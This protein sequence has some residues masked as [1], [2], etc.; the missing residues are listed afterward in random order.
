MIGDADIGVPLDRPPI[1]SS[2]FFL[3]NGANESARKAQEIQDILT[4]PTASLYIF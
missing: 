1:V 3:A 4:S 2:V